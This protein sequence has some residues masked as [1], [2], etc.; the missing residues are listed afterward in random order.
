MNKRVEFNVH[1]KLLY[2]FTRVGDLLV[3]GLAVLESENENARLDRDLV[4][5]GL[6]YMM[7]RHPLLR[8]RIVASS[9][10]SNLFYEIKDKDFNVEDDDVSFQAI[11]RDELE[12]SLETSISNVLISQKSA[13]KL[14]R[15]EIYEIVPSETSDKKQHAIAFFIPLFITD[16]LNITALL[17]ELVN[18]INSLISNQECEEMKNEL[19]LV[20]NIYDLIRKSSYLTEERQ[21]NMDKEN[22]KPIVKFKLSEKFRLP[23]EKGSK[24][25][26]FTLDS[27]TTRNLITIAKRKNTKL[28]GFITACLFYALRDLYAEN[29]LEMP[30]EVLFGI[31]A[32]LRFR[33]TP[34]INYSSLRGFSTLSLINTSYPHFGTY[35]NV[36]EDAKYLGNLI[37][38]KTS[39]ESGTVLSEYFNFDSMNET[40]ELF[41]KYSNVEEICSLLSEKSEFDIVISNAG[42]YLQN[43]NLEKLK[44]PF[45]IKEIYFTDSTNSNPPIDACILTHLSY[46][47]DQLMFMLT[48]NKAGIGSVTA[49]RF[50]QLFQSNLEKFSYEN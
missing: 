19:E 16:A 37:T 32:N 30:K 44:T 6:E 4:I 12:F 14:W 35:E 1:E 36:W 49:N 13:S 33:L 47:K 9:E 31:A 20:D 7:K 21:R 17:I 15:L 23:N 22:S 39:I 48:F 5:K 2:N 8:A 40:N 26:T 10:S 34:K 29:Q 50:T 18:I 11:S 43:E 24:I 45:E 27:T 46:W 42:T 3:V 38:E 28:T 25:N 41:E